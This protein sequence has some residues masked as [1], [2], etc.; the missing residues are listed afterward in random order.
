M[1][2][3]TNLLPILL[4]V[5]IGSSSVRCSP[6]ALAP[7]A[8][9]H[10]A[11]PRRTVSLSPAG[12]FAP[13]Q[14]AEIVDGVVDDCLASLR[15]HFKG[16]V[17]NDGN[18]G[19]K[20]SFFEVVAVGFACFAM[21]LVGVN[22]RGQPETAVM[23]YSDKNEGTKKATARLRTEFL[24]AGKSETYFYN[25]TG[26]V[27]HPAYAPAHLMRLAEE[28]PEVFRRVAHWQSFSSFLVARWVGRTHVPMS[29]SEAS[30]TGLLS[31][32]ALDWDDELLSF[33]PVTKKTLP[34]LADFAPLRRRE[35]EKK[36]E[37]EEEEEEEI[38]TSGHGSYLHLS[39][40]YATRWP[41]MSRSKMFLGVGDGAAANIG[42]GCLTSSRVCVTIGTSAAI[43]VTLP[44]S[45]LITLSSSSAKDQKNQEGDRE[46]EMEMS[47]NLPQGLWVYAVDS[48][49]VVVGGALSDGG[50]LMRWLA[51]LLS[52]RETA[53]SSSSSSSSSLSSSSSSSTPSS[54]PMPSSSSPVKEI[55]A[56]Q[57]LSPSTILSYLTPRAAAVP[58]GSRGLLLLPFLRPE[59]SPGYFEDATL[60]V[61]GVT[62]T[63]TSGEL[64]R[65]AMEGVALRL[66]TIFEILRP[67]IIH[68]SVEE[69]GRGK[70]KDEESEIRLVASGGGLDGSPLWRQILSD[71]LGVPLDM[72][73]V[74]R[75]TYIASVV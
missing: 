16:N 67:L 57:Q 42:S 29:V 56:M 60:T 13:M 41:E 43:R 1:N 38:V 51:D 37:Q 40:F 55:Q 59:R 49:R 27:I 34:P 20:E 47:M 71:A 61:H 26:T 58:P 36:E 68:S 53:S 8:P 39:E 30:W 9:L 44:R 69:R 10:R 72:V 66:A 15:N 35:K 52:L 54:L 25:R 33:L 5:D 3:G 11:L 62:G 48:K 32:V 50:S 45:A 74:D 64:A 2:G 70:E 19:E 22:S 7:C 31:P 17:E 21:S 23:T 65:A 73:G 14:L 46:E 18:G 24:R 4:A 63:T 6:Y 28:E 12:S 75:K